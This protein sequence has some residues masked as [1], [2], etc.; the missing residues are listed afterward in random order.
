M[1]SV[2]FLYIVLFGIQGYASD[3]TSCNES[4]WDF[5]PQWRERGDCAI[6]SLFILLKMEG[7][8]VKLEDLKA[9][10][11]IDPEYGSSLN[12]L[13]ETASQYGLDVEI[14]FV[15]P[16]DLSCL[17]C[18]YII[19]GITSIEKNIGHCLVIID[20]DKTHKNFT[21]IDPIL[22]KY[23]RKHENVVKQGFSGYILIPRLST[24]RFWDKL[25]GASLIITGLLAIGIL[26][27]YNYTH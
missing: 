27:R 4:E 11:K 3:V 21:I 23:E 5:A 14:R 17:T 9:S 8:N 15:K 7:K 19:H 13:K 6:N 16:D 1:G 26:L 10:V 22:G 2:L 25:A 18:P 12:V 20:Y 24:A